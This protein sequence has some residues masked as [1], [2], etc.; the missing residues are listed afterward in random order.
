M[1]LPSIST[2]TQEII[3]VDGLLYYNGDSSEASLNPALN[4]AMLLERFAPLTSTPQKRSK[5]EVCLLINNFHLSLTFQQTFAK[6]QVDYVLGKNSMNGEHIPS[7]IVTA[8]NNWTIC[9]AIYRWSQ[10]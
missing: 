6:R 8:L 4:A 10:P 9:S 1:L 5:Y 7:L 2:L 3:H